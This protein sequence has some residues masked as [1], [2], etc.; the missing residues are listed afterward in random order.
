[1]EVIAETKEEVQETKEEKVNVLLN[2]LVEHMTNP[3][4]EKRQ[5]QTLI[6]SKGPPSWTGAD[7]ERFKGEVTHWNEESKETDY[8]KYNELKEVLKKRKD[9][10]LIVDSILSRTEIEGT[11]TVKG[12]MDLLEDKF[13]KTYAEKVT[14]LL[15]EMDKLKKIEKDDPGEEVWDHFRKIVSEFKRLKMSEHPDY[16]LAVMMID[17]L[18]VGKKIEK[19]D[20]GEEVWDHFRKIMSFV[21]SDLQDLI[22]HSDNHI[23]GL[24]CVLP[25]QD[26]NWCLDL[27]HLHGQKQSFVLFG[28]HNH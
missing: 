19:D 15:K 21:C 3:K 13:G 1:M 14:D 17:G 10:T 12:I 2:K 6:K 7:Y 4:T 28:L 23:P 9:L 27:S 18:F 25:T 5:S 24:H 11:R 22:F 16:M 20:P 26:W 8:V